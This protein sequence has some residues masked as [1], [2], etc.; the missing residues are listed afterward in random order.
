[1]VKEDQNKIYKCSECG[2]EFPK[3]LVEEFILK[4][5]TAY[6]ENCGYPYKLDTSTQ[7][8]QE[9]AKTK[10]KKTTETQN[11]LHSSPQ[12]ISPIKPITPY[13]SN[14]TEPN[15]LKKTEPIKARKRSQEDLNKIN[16]A[17]QKLNS[18]VQS[19]VL[20]IIALII[21]IARL[22]VHIIVLS[23]GGLASTI[24]NFVVFFLIYTYV[25]NS[26]TSRIANKD[27][28]NIG[29][30][31]I[32]FGSIAMSIYGLGI[33]LFIEGILL[34]LFEIFSRQNEV[35]D[36]NQNLPKT[37]STEMLARSIYVMRLVLNRATLMI[38]ILSIQNL[39]VFSLETIFQIIVFVL[40]LLLLNYIRKEFLPKLKSTSYDELDDDFL[41]RSIIFSALCLGN[42]AGSNMLILCVF[43][44]IHKGNIAEIKKQKKIQDELSI[45]PGEQAPK[46]E[47]QVNP[48]SPQVN[49]TETSPVQEIIKTSSEKK[50]EVV[51]SSLPSPLVPI[52]SKD[53]KNLEIPKEKSI[54]P[55]DEALQQKKEQLI[56]NTGK[57]LGNAD[58]EDQINLYLERIFTV[59]SGETRKR[60]LELDIPETEKYD[61]LKEF[62]YLQEEQQK[63][64]LEELENINRKISWDLVKKI[65]SLKLSD[66]EKEKLIKQ[67]E[68]MT[69]ANQLEFVK[70]LTSE[71]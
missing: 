12:P 53:N 46:N 48:I 24:L 9:K 33:P 22:P 47:F 44:Y 2:Y 38:I 62:V 19:P 35:I 54:I 34:L 39:M 64:Y 41:I 23:V 49:Y 27:Y 4:N 63:K 52:Q 57:I 10:V 30:D 58:K 55:L 6:C 32:I 15:S 36:K 21:T 40:S 8:H 3:E 43:L 7:F 67:L 37:I 68:Y 31:A 28:S 13:Y 17:I 25:N 71:P 70:F 66:D 56:P 60:I 45:K 16:S 18:F 14:V 51:S 59:L 61:V 69:P 11:M 42:G 26:I 5:K 29:I 20:F 1:M 50:N 65:R